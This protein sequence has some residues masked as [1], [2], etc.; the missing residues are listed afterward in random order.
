MSLSTS[1]VQ[2]LMGLQA[3]VQHNALYVAHTFAVP[4]AY[5]AVFIHELR[6]HYAV[7]YV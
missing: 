7:L 6:I 1:D 3:Y 2:N 5:I 4:M